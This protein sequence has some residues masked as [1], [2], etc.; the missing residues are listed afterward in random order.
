MTHEALLSDT[1]QKFFSDE[2]DL[3]GPTNVRDIVR[4]DV[5]FVRTKYGS[6]FD[7]SHV[8]TFLA[9]MTGFVSGI[10]SIAEKSARLINSWRTSKELQQEVRT[11]LALPPGIDEKLFAEI[12]NYVQEKL[13]TEKAMADSLT[14][15]PTAVPV[16]VEGAKD[17][18]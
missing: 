2:C 8:L 14:A 1:L 6:N 15:E 13:E 3:A 17:P 16:H 10:I 5:E 7:L 9:T 11:S 18:I 4:G 12:C